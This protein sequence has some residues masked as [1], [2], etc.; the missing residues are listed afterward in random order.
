MTTTWHWT[1]WTVSRDF[2]WPPQSVSLLFKQYPRA[3]RGT[4]GQVVMKNSHISQVTRSTCSEGDP[5]LNQALIRFS[6]CGAFSSARK[7]NRFFIYRQKP[8]NHR[9]SSGERSDDWI[10]SYQRPCG[11][12]FGT[13]IEFSWLFLKISP[14][15]PRFSIT[16]PRRRG[17]SSTL[18][19]SESYAESF[20]KTFW[21]GWGCRQPLSIEL[22]KRCPIARLKL[23][24]GTVETVVVTS[25]NSIA[26]QADDL[27]KN[28]HVW[29]ES[30]T[31]Q[32]VL[33]CLAEGSDGAGGGGWMCLLPPNQ[34][35]QRP[36]RQNLCENCLFVL[37]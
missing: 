28:L 10:H 11:T 30:R 25:E 4:A 22:Y 6:K 32:G 5:E 16:A 24:A 14:P 19:G 21:N 27:A 9:T 1:W 31:P 7:K 8:I 23:T 35:F 26:M 20:K 13:C 3:G 37:P 29:D 2:F 18:T 15:F 34:L 17:H 33:G 36:R 12:L